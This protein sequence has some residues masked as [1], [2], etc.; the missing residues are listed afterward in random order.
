MT[1]K[2][3]ISDIDAKLILKEILESIKSEGIREIDII[4][5]YSRSNLPLV[6]INRV[7]EELEID[8][9]VKEIE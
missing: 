7:M 2:E 8:D 5:L 3:S 4:D 9:L 1:Y 6:Q